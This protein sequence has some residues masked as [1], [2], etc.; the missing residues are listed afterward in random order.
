MS[1][2]RRF[3]TYLFQYENGRKESSCGFAKLEARQGRCRMEVQLRDCTDGVYTL[4]LF[5]AAKR[6]PVGVRIGEIRVRGGSGR[7]I[8]LFEADAVGESP[9]TLDD[10]NGIRLDAEGGRMIVSQW[11][12]AEAE[13]GEFRV[14]GAAKTGWDAEAEEYGEADEADP[15]EFPK[16][17]DTMSVPEE[18]AQEDVPDRNMNQKNTEEKDDSDAETAFYMSAWEK[19][20]QR[21]RSSHPVLCPFDDAQNVY[22]IKMDLRELRVLPKEYQ[23]LANNSFLLHGYFNYRYLLFGYICEEEQMRW[24]LAVPGTFQDQEQLLAGIFGFPEFRLQHAAQQKNGAF[25]FWYRYLDL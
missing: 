21:F 17:K 12:D 23:S 10:M 25:G 16:E 8:F 13:F 4:Y 22:A 7:D 18:S 14:Y 2:Y 19:Q 3:V 9:Y 15:E 5:H 24:F 1:V 6:G 20:W 11:D